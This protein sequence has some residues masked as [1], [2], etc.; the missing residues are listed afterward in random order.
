MLLGSK[1]KEVLEMKGQAKVL[2]PA[3]IGIAILLLAGITGNKLPRVRQATEIA[4]TR[5]ITLE[6]YRHQELGMAFRADADTAAREMGLNIAAD[7]TVELKH[8]PSRVVAQATAIK[9]E[10]G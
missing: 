5:A 4:E 2:I 8:Q 9:R 7:L 1:S 6:N 3:L 10:R